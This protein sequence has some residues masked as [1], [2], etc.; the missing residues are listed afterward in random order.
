MIR[1]DMLEIFR[2]TEICAGAKR[3]FNELFG[4][5]VVTVP[6]VQQKF[7]RRIEFF[8]ARLDGAL[9]FDRAPRLKLLRVVIV[10][11]A[12]RSLCGMRHWQVELAIA[13]LADEF[14]LEELVITFK[15]FPRLL[16][17]C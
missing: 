17:C 16:L 1:N 14:R 8:G 6:V 5:V 10:Q 15:I 7:V 4:L 3:A 13:I 9:Q 12:I 2:E 11:R